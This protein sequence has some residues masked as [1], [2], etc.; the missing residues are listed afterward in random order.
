M[1]SA[2]IGKKREILG[3]GAGC[4]I[5]R[6]GEGGGSVEGDFARSDCL[7]VLFAALT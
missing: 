3:R 2:S 4:F 5:E 6:V 7:K 1:E